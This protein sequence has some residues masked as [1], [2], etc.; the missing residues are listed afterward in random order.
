[1]KTILRIFCIVAFFSFLFSCQKT[2]EFDNELAGI[3]LKSASGCGE[4]FLV[5]PS[6][7]DDTQALKDAFEDAKASGPGATVQL[8]EGIYTIGPIDV[9]DFNGCL[10]G[11]GKTKT[12]ISN[13]PELPCEELYQSDNL[14]YLMQ[15]I[16]GNVLISDLAFRIKDGKPCAE[17][18][19]NAWIGD[20][21][22]TVL[23]LG[24][25][26]AVYD[27]PENRFIKGVV[28]NVDF[29]AGK[30]NDG[31]NPFGMEG[32]VN[33]TLYCG[34]SYWYT[35]GNEP[36]SNGE[37][38]VTGC[39]FYQNNVGPDFCGFAENSKI[40]VEKNKIEG[41]TYGMFMFANLGAKF[42]INNNTFSDGQLYGLWIED[43]EWGY[44]PN[45]VL[46]NQTEWNITGNKIP[47]TS[48]KCWFVSG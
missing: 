39:G 32:N 10:I 19:T 29:I 42:T 45:A 14:P 20:L 17:S 27:I 8:T 13:L 36:L 24:D 16:G 38:K 43:N 22:C 34:P 12:F 28:K 3:E 1:M 48:R 35:T 30:I 4:V 41:G 11:A 37:I 44:Y 40:V 26:H 15:F 31:N 18:P 21:L 9:R 6:G 23:I 46:N 47:G 7:G 2:S 5:N 33:M 25:F